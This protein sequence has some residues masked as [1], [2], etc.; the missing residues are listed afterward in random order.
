LTVDPVLEADLDD[1]QRAYGAVWVA[2]GN[3]EVV[4]SVAIRVIDGG[5]T[6]ELKR[7]YLQP[8]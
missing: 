1:P 4:G 8:A 6:A 2:A 3:H 7:M 5:A